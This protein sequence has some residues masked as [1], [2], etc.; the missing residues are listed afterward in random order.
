M[1]CQELEDRLTQQDDTIK[2]LERSRSKFKRF[3]VKYERE[4]EQRDRRIE[5]LQS[6]SHASEGV[7]KSSSQRLSFW[8]VFGVFGIP[9]LLFLVMSILWTAWLIILTLAPNETANYLM[10]TGDYDDGHF[11][12]LAEQELWI[13]LSR[14]AGL[15]LA[16]VGYLHI[17][18]KMLVCRTVPASFA[19]KT[20][21]IRKAS[22][23]NK[24]VVLPTRRRSITL[25]GV[26][27]E[28]TGINGSYR[29]FWNLAHKTADL[30]TQFILLSSHLEQGF[31]NTLVYGWA[32]FISCNCLSCVLNIL[33]SKFSALTEILVDSMFD[34]I[35]TIVYPVFT[36]IYC[37][38]NFQFDHEVFR[39][40]VQVLPPGSFEI[41]AR[42]FADP[43][44]VELFRV[45]FNSLR[46]QTP[47]LLVIHLLMNLSFWHRF[48]GV[49]EVMMRTNGRLIYPSTRSKI[50]SR[51]QIRVPKPIALFFALLGVLV[52]PYSH[53]AIQNSRVGC[54]PYAECLVYA[55]RFPWSFAYQDLCP[56]R[57]LVDIDR[58]PS[59]Y[60]QWSNPVD[61]T[62]KVKIL[63]ASGDL[64]VLRL[65][66]RQLLELPDELQ[67]CQLEHLTLIYTSTTSLPDWTSNWKSLE[68]LHIEGKQGS[69]NLGYLPSD[70]FSD[71]PHLLFLHLALHRSLTSL[72]ALDGTPRLQTLEL[73]HL[74]GLTRLPDLDNTVDLHGIVI[75]YL[76]LLETLPDLLQLK[77]LVSV[78]V[79]RPSFLCCNG[80]LGSCD[81]THPFCDAD[82]THGFLAAACL[83][84][85]RL[86]ASSAMINYLA[87]FGATVC[88]KTPDSLLEFADIPTKASVD[89]CG[90]V[91]YRRCEIVDPMTNEVLKG[92]CYNLRMQ[93][94]SCNPDPFN[95]AVRKRQI[96][97][98]VGTP[99]DVQEEG[100]LGC[101]EAKS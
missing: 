17:M 41:I 10:H 30:I 18:V 14:I 67:S 40:Y 38:H 20:G 78:T 35:A 11:W 27:N 59:T 71:M 98:N 55:H 56:C 54:S 73:A 72:P 28:L 32:A 5:E 19:V 13:K 8:Q 34:L 68:F 15:V 66:N 69:E 43:A 44:Q 52:A 79:F 93:V 53:Y 58:A 22:I 39:T 74:F 70:L 94:L 31:P 85:A 23:E 64:K 84:D 37:Y 42:L 96:T 81:L 24:K 62:D 65:I 47:L 12:L 63:A 33:L 16:V 7:N 90:G 83:T 82:T 95:I 26:W 99:C 29:K 45:N 97:L 86:Q 75:A 89:M 36:L 6:S 49:T 21:G 101:I 3:A 100:W 4:I 57:T 51:H 60:K 2:Q 92:M 25:E 50:R 87:S 9:M 48:K 91:P 76:P 46:D 88:Y 80:Y 77:H 61:V 1:K